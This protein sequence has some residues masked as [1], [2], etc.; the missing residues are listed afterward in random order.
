MN[1]FVIEPLAPLVV[2]TGRPFDDQAGLDTARFPPPS[3]LAGALRTAHA[4]TADLPFGPELSALN[5]RGPL[6]ARWEMQAD[7][8]RLSLLVPKPADALYFQTE[9]KCDSVL[10]AASPQ[11]LAPGEGMD[12]PDGLLPVRLTQD[13]KGKPGKGPLWWPLDALI[14]MRRGEMPSMDNLKRHGWTPMPDERRSHV[15]IDRNAQAAESGKLFQ[16][17]GMVFANDSGKPNSIEEPIVLLGSLDGDIDEG[18]ITLGGERRLA[19]IHRPDGEVWPQ[20][21]SGLGQQ[22][23]DSGGLC[24]TLLTPAL[25]SEGWRPGWLDEN[26][27]GVPPEA[28]GIRLKL[29]AAAVDRWLPQSG[30]DIASNKPRAGRKMVAAGAVYWFE[31]LEGTPEGFNA[32]WMPHLSDEPQD[33]RDGFGL[34]LGMPWSCPQTASNQTT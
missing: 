20:P 34:A 4:I 25:F 22:I 9:D 6:P 28:Q 7:K 15:A 29:R 13:I 27:E 21:P 19:S 3:T 17:A 5:A 26:L 2:R 23:H 30:W 32:L 31:V 12:L 11:T 10:S 16:T 8:P 33:R 18:V 1:A 14:N 24:L